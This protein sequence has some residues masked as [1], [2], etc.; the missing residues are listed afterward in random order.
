MH[1]PTW[2]TTAQVR[3]LH[4]E[5]LRLFGGS[6]GLRD[7]NLL[8]SALARPRQRWLAEWIKQNALSRS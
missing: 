2:L 3:M 8:E 7:A 6:T 5:S 1:E 4:A